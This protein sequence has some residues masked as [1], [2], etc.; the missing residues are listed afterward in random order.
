MS[1][2]DESTHTKEYFVKKYNE[3]FRNFTT[4]A[5]N[6]GFKSTKTLYNW[7]TRIGITPEEIKNSTPLITH[8]DVNFEENTLSL[9]DFEKM[10][11]ERDRQMIVDMIENRKRMWKDSVKGIFSKDI[12]VYKTSILMGKAAKNMTGKVTISGIELAAILDFVIRE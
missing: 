1:K 3:A 11:K 7:F 4:M 9:H 2:F 5:K 12:I 6:E 8:Y 10:I